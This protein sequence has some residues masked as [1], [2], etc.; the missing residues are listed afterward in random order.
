MLQQFSQQADYMINNNQH[1][2]INEQKFI[3]FKI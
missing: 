3:T 1:T 2:K